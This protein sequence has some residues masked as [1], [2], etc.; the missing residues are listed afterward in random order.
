MVKSKRS[1]KSKKSSKRKKTKVMHG[2]GCTDEELRK[3]ADDLES[4]RSSLH[5]GSSGIIHY[6]DNLRKSI[7]DGDTHLKLQVT[8]TKDSVVSDQKQLREADKRLEDF[9]TNIRKKLP[10]M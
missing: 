2:G 6:V 7:E 10:K 1:K 9:I 3:I 4:I 8:L 5:Y